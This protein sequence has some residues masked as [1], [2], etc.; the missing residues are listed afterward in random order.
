MFMLFNPNT[1]ESMAVKDSE[2][3]KILNDEVNPVSFPLSDSVEVLDMTLR[4]FILTSGDLS[5]PEQA[6]EILIKFY[7]EKGKVVSSRTLY[8]YFGQNFHYCYPLSLIKPAKA[9]RLDIKAFNVYL[10]VVLHSS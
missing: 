1:P 6:G 9:R 2:L 10:D 7:D 8:L 3:S 4:R 5:I